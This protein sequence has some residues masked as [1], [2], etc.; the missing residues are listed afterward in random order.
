MT[1]RTVVADDEPLARQRLVRLLEGEPGAELVAACG[2]G[3]EVVETVRR[4]RPDLIFLD[5]QMPG[6][7][8]FEALRAL[9]NDAPRAIVFVTA[10]NAYALQAFEAN[11]LDYLL[12]PF[13]ADRFHRAFE[14]ARERLRGPDP[15]VPDRLAQ[16]LEKLSER[17]P[18]TERLVVRAEG[19][20]YLVRTM[21]IDWIETASNY[22]RLH[23]GKTSH[24]LRESL[25]SLETR[26]DPARF[27]RIHRT[28]IVN[29]ERLREL[30]PW[31]S[32]EF[33][34]ILQDGTR[35]KVSRG[36]REH[37][38]RWLGHTL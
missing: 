9:G 23:T 17:H 27:L 10:F 2:T 18:P 30:Q 33:V 4:V 12:K 31:F 26:L 15:A 14:R 19:R 20:V 35:L 24:L 29:M 22:V 3:T 37:V 38:A 11:A 16:L 8:G 21:D 1:V 25:S 28:T 34:A 6:L 5:V 13:D 36:Y 7:D 32:G